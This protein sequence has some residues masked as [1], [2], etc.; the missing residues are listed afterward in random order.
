MTANGKRPNTQSDRINRSELFWCLIARSNQI[1]IFFSISMQL[2][3]RR[4]IRTHICLSRDDDDISTH[5]IPVKVES[6]TS[7]LSKV[8]KAFR[9]RATVNKEG[10][11]GILPEEPDGCWLRRPFC[12][13]RCK[14]D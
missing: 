6:H 13:R 12:V 10:C 1:A 4:I 2:I 7:I 14:P 5:P 9:I 11:C 3:C 8:L